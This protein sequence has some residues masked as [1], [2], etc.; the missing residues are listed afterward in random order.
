MHCVEHSDKF[1]GQIHWTVPPLI[2]VYVHI[3]I[4]SYTHGEGAR[5]LLVSNLSLISGH[6]HLLNQ[7]HNDVMING[8]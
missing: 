3:V 7:I 5:L 4:V 1:T 2:G 6:K 8:S